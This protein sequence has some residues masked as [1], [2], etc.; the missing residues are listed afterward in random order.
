MALLKIQFTIVLLL[1]IIPQNS[2]SQM[3]D[4]S[5]SNTIILFS[6][7]LSNQ[8][9]IDTVAVAN[10]LDFYGFFKTINCTSGNLYFSG[11]GFP[12]ITSIKY[13]GNPNELKIYFDHCVSGSRFTFENC[14]FPRDGGLK[15]LV[16]S[17]SVLFL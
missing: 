1:W 14:S 16:L 3:P 2:F 9:K 4:T 17:K 10:K 8:K 6:D 5:Y 15:P 13:H 7:F 11:N 12:K